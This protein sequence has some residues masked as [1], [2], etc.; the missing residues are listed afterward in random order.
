M[1]IEEILER[2]NKLFDDGNAVLA[3]KYNDSSN[4]VFGSKFE[5]EV[6]EE[7][8]IK[9]KLKC[10]SYFDQI[11]KEDN[12]RLIEFQNKVQTNKYHDVKMGLAILES[13]MED[14][15][16]GNFNLK[17][18]FIQNNFYDTI[19]KILNNFHKVVK[20]L[21]DRHDG[22]QTIEIKDEYDVPDLMLVLIHFSDDELKVD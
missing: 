2:L 6:D 17:E 14:I 15:S 22:R 8:F 18:T 13:T 20:Q 1:K 7:K 16:D 3:T 19:E 21:R 12:H 10:I 5:D 11:L 4:A 9:W